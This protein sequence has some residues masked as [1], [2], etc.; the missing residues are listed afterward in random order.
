MPQT[1]QLSIRTTLYLSYAIL[2]ALLLLVAGASLYQL[3]A[4]KDSFSRYINGIDHRAQLAGQLANAAKDR[5][6]ALRNLV[7]IVDH[8]ERA[9]QRS[10]VEAA[11][12][13]VTRQLDALGLEIAQDDDVSATARTLFNNIQ[14]IERRYEPIAKNIADQVFAGQDASAIEMIARQC[15]PLLRELT[16]AI[17]EYLDYTAKLAAEQLEQNDASYRQ[18]RALLLGIA[19]FSALLAIVL[20]HLITRRLLKALGA[21]PSDLDRLAQ[22]VAEGD[23]RQHAGA[24]SGQG[25]LGSLRQMQRNLRD[26]A[27][28]IDAS[29]QSVAAASQE[30]AESSQLNA[31]GVA[32]AQ[33]EIEQIVTAIHEMSA[34]VQDVARNAEAAA[35]AAGEADTAAILGQDKTRHAVDLIGEL[36]GVIDR[37]AEAMARLKQESGNIGSVLDVIKAVAEQTNLLALNAAIEAARAGEAGRGFAVVADEVRGLA[38]RTQGATAEIESL[39]GNLQRIADETAQYMQHCQT[40]SQQSVGGVSEA[41]EAVVRIVGMI[42]RINGMNQQ[43]AAAAEEQ[44]TVAEQIGQSIVAVRDNSAQSA[45]AFAAT[46]RESESLARTSEALRENI[47]RF[48]L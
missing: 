40:S 4:A 15:T 20:G 17:D 16:A 37:S 31:A 41:G 7:L 33:Q 34:T 5:A 36:A 35:Q 19:L 24:E 38:Q 48:Q 13:L 45:E 30:M 9:G 22:Q 23:L 2:V 44:S 42:E 11:S 6:I 32:K 43:I 3:A 27:Q 1:R 18:Q 29:S 39:I 25:V 26:M 8:A 21:E 14:A 10:A 47:A 12:N 46:Q 28:R